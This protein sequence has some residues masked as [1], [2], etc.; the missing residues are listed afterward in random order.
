MSNITMSLNDN[1]IQKVRK[2]AIDKHTTLTGM[3][4][5]YLYSVAKKDEI[6]KSKVI[7]ELTELYSKSTAVV[8]DKTWTREDLYE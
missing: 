7:Q 1:L 2:I 3:V 4:R 8:G 5:Q 6:K